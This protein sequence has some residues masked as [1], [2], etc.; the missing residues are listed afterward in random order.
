MIF[1]HHQWASCPLVITG[2]SICCILSAWSY[3]TELTGKTPIGLN[4]SM[5]EQTPWTTFTVMQRVGV[6]LVSQLSPVVG[7]WRMGVMGHRRSLGTLACCDDLVL[8]IRDWQCAEERGGWDY[9][10]PKGFTATIL[11]HWLEQHPERGCPTALGLAA[12]WDWIFSPFKPSTSE[13]LNVRLLRY[14]C[15]FHPT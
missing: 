15:K 13:L 8:G 12:R 6:S 4:G 1:I 9:T 10:V 11:T 3:P 2:N 7:A 5:L 14:W